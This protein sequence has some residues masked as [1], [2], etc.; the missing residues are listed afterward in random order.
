MMKTTEDLKRDFEASKQKMY[1]ILLEKERKLEKK[2]EVL[3]LKVE[4]LKEM[5]E[6]LKNF[7][8]RCGIWRRRSRKSPRRPRF[9]LQ[10][11]F[12]RKD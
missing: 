5:D 11:L 7:V 10:K 12:W 1:F 6:E 2:N 3:L 9:L 8:E 4:K